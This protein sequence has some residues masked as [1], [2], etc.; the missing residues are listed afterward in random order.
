MAVLSQKSAADWR[1]STTEAAVGCDRRRGREGWRRAKVI[2]VRQL[3]E[4]FLRQLF[5]ASAPNAVAQ[6]A[7]DYARE[8]VAADLSWCGITK[9]GFLTMAAHNGLQTTEMMSL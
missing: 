5:S 3:M 2:G 8:C 9:D 1:L 4:R 6:A 7:V